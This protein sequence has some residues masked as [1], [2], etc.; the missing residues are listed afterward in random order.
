VGNICR[1]RGRVR[2]FGLNQF[3]CCCWGIGLSA[4]LL[5]SG[6][7]T[8]TKRQ[9]P[10][11]YPPTPEAE[12]EELRSLPSVPYDRLAILTVVA[13]PGEQLARSIERARAIAAQKGANAIV[14]QQTNEYSQRSG[15]KRVKVWRI[16]Y[17][18]IHRR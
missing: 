16:T 9:L 3:T 7:A 14:V 5:A 18:A 8:H 2:F 12:L 15:R 11:T 13:E 10:P 6:C 1:N 17:L 4:L